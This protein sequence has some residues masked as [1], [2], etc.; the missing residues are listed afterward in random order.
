[1]DIET[2]RKDIDKIDDAIIHLLTERMVLIEKLKNLKSSIIDKDREDFI[3]SKTDS[4]PI[5]EIYKTIFKT[6]KKILQ[7]NPLVHLKENKG[8][9]PEL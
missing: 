4:E 1:M 6:S 7:K 9:N 5:Q 8:L 3:L 2:I